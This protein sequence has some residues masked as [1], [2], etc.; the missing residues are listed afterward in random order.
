MK[1]PSL[2][3]QRSDGRPPISLFSKSAL[4]FVAVG[5]LLS[6]WPA[7]LRGGV[8]WFGDSA[9]YL[10]EGK[11]LWHAI[12]ASIGIG[13]DPAPWGA[14]LS[15]QRS[16]PYSA[17]VGLPVSVGLF[18]G[19]ANYVQ[20]CLMLA[21]V[22]PLVARLRPTWLAVLSVAIM[23]LLTPFPFFAV[24]L[25][26]DIFAAAVILYGILLVRVWDELDIPTRIATSVI[27]LFAVATHYG[28]LPLAAAVL[29]AAIGVQLWRGRLGYRAV[30]LG[31]A[32][33]AFAAALNI[34]IGVLAFDQASLAPKRL[35]IL[36]ARSMEDG[37]ALWYLERA[38][39]EHGYAICTF[40]NGEF[41]DTVRGILW[42]EDGLGHAD[43]DVLERVRAEEP[44]ILWR[45]LRDYPLRQTQSLAG[46]AAL[47]LVTVGTGDLGYGVVGARATLLEA[48]GDVH[49]ASYLAGIA[50]LA[51]LTW[52]APRAG[53]AV[54]VLAV[55]LLANAAIFGGLSAPVDRYQ[56]RVAWL[57]PLLALVLLLENRA[58][59]AAPDGK[60]PKRQ[61]FSQH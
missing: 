5:A 31:T 61:T 49:L 21:L 55:G 45:A 11:A 51:L 44:E 12:F 33:L 30:M 37:P 36:L 59:A 35:P 60:G 38:C 39:P 46:N 43:P 10:M 25:M 23:L 50:A 42:G 27:A 4:V 40:W 1:L 53:G 57:V 20:A 3:S 58:G 48:M 54:A 24:Y 29:A 56:A 47:Q 9:W 14:V 2:Q 6:M 34:A 22:W 52:R 16:L 26:P 19:A 18:A 41:P 28:N 15:A 7:F 32:T 8:L 13:S 17:F